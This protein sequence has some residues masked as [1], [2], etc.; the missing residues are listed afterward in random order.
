MNNVKSV[1]SIKDLEHLS[2]IKAHTIR[3]WEKRYNLLEP[4]R[5]DTNI[6][7]Y[8]IDSL[9]KLLNI[10]A[11]YNN[12]VK[13]SKIAKLTEAELIEKSKSLV[14]ASNDNHVLN[15]F[16]ISAINFDKELFITTYNK[17]EEQNDFNYIF[18]EVFIPLLEELG[19]LWQTKTIT[20]AQE[21][22]VSELIKQKILVN[23]EKHQTSKINKLERVYALYL[24]DNE[25]H[26][27]GLQFLNYELT[28]LGYQTIYLGASVPTDSLTDLLKQYD[29]VSFITYFTVKPDDEDIDDYLKEFD[30]LLLKGENNLLILGRKA[31]NIKNT[32]S[33]KIKVFNTIEKLI[34]SL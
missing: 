19:F 26:E 17:L 20:P 8:S 25:V 34:S 30:N 4:N 12:G 13:I 3:I 2:G 24:P 22:F 7:N 6:R 23:T 31:Q 5:S 14:I 27:L 18:Y 16:K 9:K 28:R 15:T 10:T 29:K 1:F 32:G 33:K 21:H 11:L